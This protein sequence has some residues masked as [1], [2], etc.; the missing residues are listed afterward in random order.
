MG[1]RVIQRL[2]KSV[3]G[4]AFIIG[5]ASLLSRA[6]GLVR[7]RLLTTGFGAGDITDVY[8]AAFKI[9]DFIFNLL[10]LGALMAS[11]VPLFIETKKKAGTQ[12]AFDLAAN[13]LNVMMIAFVAVAAV[14]GVFA[15][16]LVDLLAYGD[17]PEQQ[18][19]IVLFTRIMLG[20]T[21]FFAL[22]NVLAG[23]LHSLKRFFIYSLSPI[24]YNIGIIVGIVVLH[25]LVG[26][27]GLPLGVVLG[28]LLQFLVLVPTALSLGFRFR[29]KISLKDPALRTMLKLMPPQ[30][31][32]LG[33]TQLNVI[34]VF[35][36]A[37]TFDT[38]ARSVWQYADNLQ[39]FPINIFGVSLALA[40]FPVFSEAF[41]TNDM[42]R[43]RT[44][45]SENVRRILFFI[46]PISIITLLLRA[47]IVRLVY[48]AGEFDWTD[49]VLTAQTLG[50]FA[51][52]MFAQ[53][54]MPLFTRAFF[55][56]QDTKTPVII[57][58][59]SMA[60]NV[61]LALIFVHY[62]ILGGGI[63]SLGFAF[64]IAAIVQMLLLLAVLRV[65]Y[66]DLD[67]DHIVRSAWHIILAAGVM[68]FVVQ[69]LKYVVAPMVNMETVVGVFIQAV[70][71]TL[72]G[73]IVYILIAERFHFDEAIAVRKKIRSVFQLLKRRS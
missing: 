66:G 73:A 53:A 3:M 32:A 20:A 34:I 42:K 14:A 33:L 37:S 2:Q 11:F 31:L 72:G 6:L 1:Q 62:S 65:R 51:L 5:I 28:G 35:A 55:A 38:G 25:P 27:I 57:A 24:V 45:F 13:A 46:I 15:P 69:G 39:H 54:L 49:T 10:V 8:F 41:A 16:Q 71:A 56:K 59:I 52:S 67:D 63:I 36:I 7:D 64:S 58:M 43:F 61:A 47:Q 23:V 12:A 17:S 22:S 21:F 26:D 29:A 68:G 44:V 48:G 40:V 30:A 4:G 60:L 50:V 70:V 18:I 9:P 19:Q